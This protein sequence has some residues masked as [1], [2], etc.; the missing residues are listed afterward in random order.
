MKIKKIIITGGCGF[1]GSSLTDFLI[2]KGYEIY[3]IDNFSNNK[4][5]KPN[6]KS[7]FYKID[8][9]NIDEINKI[10]NVHA[11][12]HL[13]AIADILISKDNEKKYFN[14]NLKGFQDVLNF[15]SNNKI[16]KLIFASSASVY[17]NKDKTAVKEHQSLDP[18]HYYA[19]SKL[20]G[21]NM[22][23]LYSKI[24]KFDYTILRFFNIYGPKS[25]AVISTFLAKKLQKKKI[26]I[27][28]NGKQ[29]RDFLYIDDLCDAILKVLENKK[30]KNETYNL[31]SGKSISINELKNKLSYKD[32]I[33]LEK[34]NDDIEVSIA[35]ISK[36]K[37]HLNWFPKISIEEGLKR[38]MENDFYRL[39]KMKIVSI[40][41]LKKIIKKF[42]N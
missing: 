2:N 31:G 30:A 20:I 7:K 1:I 42:N 4:I 22:L 27:F 36:I 26:T 39:K 41:N 12:I 15:C 16:K 13:A 8:I 33:N 11:I 25:N 3:I 9:R 32:Y 28:G 37:K 34:R 18:G 14:N 17:G 29:K 24:N 38:S 35:N 19:Y 10:K 40:S 6:K 21:E 23:K 5:T